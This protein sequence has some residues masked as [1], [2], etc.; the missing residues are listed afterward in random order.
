MR[1]LLKIVLIL[2]GIAVALPL[3]AVGGFFAWGWLNTYHAKWHQRMELVIDTPEGEVRGDAVQEARFTAARGTLKK[4]MRVNSGSAGYGFRGEAVVVE[5]EPGRWLF[6]LLKSGEGS[7]GSPGLNLATL[8]GKPK[9]LYPATEETVALVKALPL[10]Q[11]LTLP[12]DLYPLMVTFDD[13][14]D[15]K[16]VRRVDPDDLDASFGCDR[17]VDPALMPWR[18]EG[19]TY[20]QWAA[21]QGFRQASAKAAA[22][23]GATGPA[24]E[25]LV[26]YSWITDRITYDVQK[27]DDEKRHTLSARFTRAEYEAWEK[28]FNALNRGRDIALPTPADIAEAAGGACHRLKAVTL[29][30]TEEAV[31]DGRMANAIPCVKAGQGCTW[32]D[33]KVPYGDPLFNLNGA[34]V[35]NY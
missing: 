33:L 32:H 15:P 5:V 25:A 13:I 8:V 7:L 31:T 9:R 11:P 20:R 24:A 21:E 22:T 6:A 4:I 26:E 23:A 3:L 12:R 14:N 18:G 2:V 29:A 1:R 19:R 35:R 17:S 27:G 16:T 10:D 34:F 28:A 30:V